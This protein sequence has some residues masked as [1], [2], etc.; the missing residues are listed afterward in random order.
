MNKYTN[1]TDKGMEAVKKIVALIIGISLILLA[2]CGGEDTSSSGEELKELT[3]ATDAA[4]A[5][6]EFMNKGE[7][8]GFDVD[9][10]TAVLEEAGYQA[11]F[12]NVGWET[13]LQN[14]VNHKADLAVAGITITD[15]RKETY[16]F[17]DPYF[18]STQLILVPEDS[19]IS[20]VKDLEDKNVGVQIS[21][22]GA[23]AA[24]KIF[25]TNSDQIHQF[26]QVPLA[27]MSM[28]QG[29]VDAV[30]VDNAVAQEYIKNNPDAK[31]KTVED[32]EAFDSEYYGFMFP[33]DNELTEEI[34]QAIET[35]IENGT[36]AE[37]YEKWFG[38]TP[39]TSVLN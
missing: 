31:I 13:M 22:T 4:F 6:F 33:K 38:Q 2:A 21:T 34:N 3:I 12:D 5:P 18:E 39:D 30:I 8:T 1:K 10:A 14:V 11:S 19:N 28:E 32:K 36:Y 25:G 23:E 37:I 20:S 15:E 7:V 17:S 35:V 29:D 26:D 16:D 27:I 9:F 24:E